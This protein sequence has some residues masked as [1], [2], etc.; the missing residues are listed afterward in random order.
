MSD[1]GISW[2]ICKSAP[3]SR[4]VTMPAPHCS[5]LYRPDA[6]HAAQPTASK[7]W[8]PNLFTINRKIF[9]KSG[10][11]SS[12]RQ[13]LSVEGRAVVVVA[14]DERDVDVG[15]LGVADVDERQPRHVAPERER[16]AQ[17]PPHVHIAHSRAAAR[18]ADDPA[19]DT[20]GHAHARI[21]GQLSLASLRGRLIEYQLWL[22]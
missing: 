10:A 6:L 12:A 19:H 17:L 3:R 4:Q 2:T 9:C 15:R 1:S 21:L 13:T 14:G 8:R 18:V 5:V 20:A 7:H 22:G 16:V 11:W